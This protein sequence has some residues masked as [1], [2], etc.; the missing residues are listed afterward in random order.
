MSDGAASGGPHG[1][2]GLVHVIEDDTDLAAALLRLLRSLSLDARAY[3]SIGA[4]LGAQRGEAPGCVLLDINLPDM[5]GLDFQEEMES[6]GLRQP[7][8][9]MTGYG[10]IPSSV[11][12]M[13]AGAV[14]FLT[15][16]FRDQDLLDAVMRALARDGQ[17]LH[18]EAERAAARH[19]FGLL[20]AR[21][22]E[23]FAGVVEGL[24]NK[25]IAAR[26]GLSIVTVK[27]HRGS[28]MRKLG[29]RS[30]ADLV[31]A[32]QSMGLSA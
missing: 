3:A 11:R 4:F 15:K 30:P 7:V 21:E 25:E 22:R 16:P 17:R 18:S 20:S 6:R 9:V 32:A 29:A 26:L 23:V 24:L 10:D 27:A 31:R 28:M 1:A 19:R 5:S 14:D 12:A 2:T 13:K 8:I